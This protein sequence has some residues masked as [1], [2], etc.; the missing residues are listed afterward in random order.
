MNL[1]NFWK[2]AFPGVPVPPV[3]K[4]QYGIDILINDLGTARWGSAIGKDTAF[5]R[6]AKLRHQCDFSPGSFFP[7]ARL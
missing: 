1:N 4:G 2:N 5:S 6:A 3:V 7:G